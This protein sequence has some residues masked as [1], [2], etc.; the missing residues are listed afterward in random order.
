MAYFFI[1]FT[2]NFF[3]VK[4]KKQSA[5]E[6]RKEN[7]KPR[8]HQRTK[9]EKMNPTKLQP[10]GIHKSIDIHDLPPINPNIP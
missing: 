5:A 8:Y 3:I 2:T 10:S 7:A 4:K 9:H 6:K 1:T